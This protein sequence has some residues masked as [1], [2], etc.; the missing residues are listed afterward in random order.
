MSGFVPWSRLRLAL[1]ATAVL[2]AVCS[3]VLAL[4]GDQDSGVGRVEAAINWPR[5]CAEVAVHDA[6]GEDP[7]PRAVKF[8]SI[9][10]EHVG[11]SVIYARFA[12]R[13]EQQRELLREPPSAPVCIAAREVVIDYLG[14][15]QFTRLCRGL[16]GDL[17]DAVSMLAPLPWDGTVGGVNRR[18]AAE[19]RRD[20]E[21]Q[22]RALRR[23]WGVS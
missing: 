20:V 4:R 9:S 18:T 11:P 15:R 22:R 10:C 19:E 21:A 16:N 12:D 17:V 3:V 23:Y 2:I 6:T 8:A 1:A 7:W 13:T 5:S 14:L